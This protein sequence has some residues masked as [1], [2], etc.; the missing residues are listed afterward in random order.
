MAVTA[1]VMAVT[2]TVMVDTATVMAVIS[3]TAIGGA[4]VKAR[5]GV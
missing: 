3:G 2:A 4:T 5:A 1:T